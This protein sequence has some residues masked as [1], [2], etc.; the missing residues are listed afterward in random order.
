MVETETA[1][2]LRIPA[3]AWYETN[4]GEALFRKGRCALSSTPMAA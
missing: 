2:E 4:R 3:F 1:E